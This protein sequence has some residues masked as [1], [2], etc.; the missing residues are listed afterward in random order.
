MA[1]PQR[2]GQHD[3]E[4]FKEYQ[5]LLNEGLRGQKLNDYL[6]KLEIHHVGSVVPAIWC[7]KYIICMTR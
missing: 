1:M 6:V 2:R 5:G 7:L 4:I 3:E